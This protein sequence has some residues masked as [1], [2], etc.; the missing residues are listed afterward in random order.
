MVS[1]LLFP[2]VSASGSDGRGRTAVDK[3]KSVITKIAAPIAP[4]D[5]GSAALLS[6]LRLFPRAAQMNLSIEVGLPGTPKGHMVKSRILFGASD[7]ALFAVAKPLKC[8]EKLLL[9]SAA[10]TEEFK[11]TVVAVMPDDKGAAVAVRFCDG[12]PAWFSPS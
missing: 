2:P 10:G 11:A 7:T 9:K 4:A 1:V 3:V 5:A 8:G 12:N 6:L